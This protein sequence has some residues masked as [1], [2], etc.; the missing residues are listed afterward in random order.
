[1]GRFTKFS[2]A[3]AFGIRSEGQMTTIR[4]LA[5]PA[6]STY[7]AFLPKHKFTVLTADHRYLK[8]SVTCHPLGEEIG[9]VLYEEK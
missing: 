3:A 9:E 1:M 5:L 6:N 8:F 2:R 7:V 4:K